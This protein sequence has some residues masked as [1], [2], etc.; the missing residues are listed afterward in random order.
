MPTENAVR[1]WHEAAPEGFLF[2]WKASRIITHLKRLKDVGENIAFVFER[3]NGLGSAFGPVLFQ[4]PPS[5]AAKPEYLERLARCLGEIPR[6]RRC[7]FEFRHASWFEEKALDILRA[8]NVALCLSDHAAAPTP[9]IVT[10]DF[11]YLRCHGKQGPYEGLYGRKTLQSWAPAIRQWRE[12][13]RDVFVYFDND[14]KSAAPKDAQT[15]I[16]L[17]G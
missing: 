4:L 2:A 15:L 10:A 9:W 8:H 1:T 13:G 5:M 16:A 12:E 14:Y 3:M 6:G 17:T 7:T 11:V